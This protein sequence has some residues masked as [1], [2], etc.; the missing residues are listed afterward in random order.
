MKKFFGVL[1]TFIAI[2][3]FAFAQNEVRPMLSTGSTALLFEFSGLANI[4]AGN[5]EGGIGGKYYLNPNL[6]LRGG[7]QFL[8]VTQSAPNDNLPDDEVSATGFGLTAAL[9]YHLR[10]GRVS[11]YLGGG[12][13]FT[14]ISTDET[15]QVAG[16][17]V[18]RSNA[19]NGVNIGGDSYNAGS[20]I[21]VFGSLGVEFFL[22]KELS[23]GAEYR[24]GF[25]STSQADEEVSQGN[26]TQTTKGGSISKIGLDSQGFITL[27]VYF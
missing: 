27:A 3:S 7:L 25:S 18:T 14:N 21:G 24:L 15:Q 4:G 8:N 26:V 11:P 23:L 16:G 12:I 17:K 1:F 13:S 19:I 5:F 9:E 2:S 6:A 22:Y 20:T 10:T